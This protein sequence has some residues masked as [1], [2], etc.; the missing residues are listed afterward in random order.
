MLFKLNWTHPTH[1]GQ[2]VTAVVIKSNSNDASIPAWP[3][4][5]VAQELYH[6][7]AACAG[8][9]ISTGLVPMDAFMVALRRLTEEPAQQGP[10]GGN[11]SVQEQ[12]TARTQGTG[13]TLRASSQNAGGSLTMSNFYQAVLDCFPDAAC[14]QEIRRFFCA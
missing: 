14:K 10:Q 1:P 6:Y 8:L 11:Q 7:V 3:E 4:T 5:S 12:Q 2:H 13:G 9:Q